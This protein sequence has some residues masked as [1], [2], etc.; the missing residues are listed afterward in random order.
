MVGVLV[1]VDAK[2]I[3]PDLA[4]RIPAGAGE[5]AGFQRQKA[6]CVAR[7]ARGALEGHARQ[8]LAGVGLQAR[9]QVGAQYRCRAQ[10]QP[11]QQ[12][13]QRVV[14]GKVACAGANAQQCVHRQVLGVQGWWRTVQKAHAGLLGGQPC[15]VGVAA[16][17][18]RI[19]Q[20]V[21]AGGVTCSLEGGGRLQPVSAVVACA[22]GQPDLAGVGGNGAPQLGQRRTCALHQAGAG[23]SIQCV[24]FNQ[25]GGGR[26]IQ[27]LT[28]GLPQ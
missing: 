3:P 13:H 21:H 7:A 19:P 10:V 17:A 12:L 4:R 16:A 23:R 25:A 8:I 20:P 6:Q 5:E 1:Q 14:R 28:A 24:G 2:V 15:G 22:A 27:R 26:V 11:L 9:R 18:L